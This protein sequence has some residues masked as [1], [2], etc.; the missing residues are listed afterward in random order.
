[1]APTSAIFG[2]TKLYKSP[3]SGIAELIGEFI[4]R[5][6]SSS[7]RCQ[8]VK[9][10]S[11][12]SAPKRFQLPSVAW[13]GECCGRLFGRHTA[14]VRFS[15]GLF[16]RIEH[17]CVELDC[18]IGRQPAVTGYIGLELRLEEQGDGLLQRPRSGVDEVR[19]EGRSRS[20]HRSRQ[21]DRRRRRPGRS[22]YGHSWACSSRDEPP[23]SIVMFA[24]WLENVGVL[25]PAF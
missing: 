8:A 6:H 18:R 25:C 7:S 5:V 1:M 16:D 4:P 19:K 3:S 20:D 21:H 11:K 14:A 24:V 15:C 22:Q 2:A 23:S 13:Q 12:K 10:R 17:G 9:A